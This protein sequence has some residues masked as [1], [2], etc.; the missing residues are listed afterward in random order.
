MADF[1]STTNPK[2]PGLPTGLKISGSQLD[3][4]ISWKP[5][6]DDIEDTIAN[7]SVSISAPA[8]D[9]TPVTP[10]KSAIDGQVVVIWLDGGTVGVVYAVTCQIVTAS[11]PPRRDSRTV[12]IEVVAKRST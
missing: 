5:W 12:Y 4:P 10:T 7:H 8:G 2:N 1:W 9:A 11:T 3:F 6:L